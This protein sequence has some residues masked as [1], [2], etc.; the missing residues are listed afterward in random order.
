M[1]GGG[2]WAILLLF[3]VFGLVTLVL[4]F[5]NSN[6]RV[7]GKSG[8]NLIP[9][10]KNTLCSGETGIQRLPNRLNGRPETGR[11]SKPPPLHCWE[12]ITIR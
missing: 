8:S 5:A 4:L 7:C 6:L 12:I 1:K 11:A 3:A 9:C 10:Y 2:G